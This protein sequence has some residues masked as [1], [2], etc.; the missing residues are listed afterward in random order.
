[1]AYRIRDLVLSILILALASWAIV[2]IILALALT[3]KRIFFTQIRTGKDEKPF[4]LIKFSTLRDILSGEKEEEAQRYRLTPVGKIILKTSLD[5]L[6]NLFNVLMG[7]MSLVGPRPLIHDYLPIYSTEQKKRFKVPPGITGWAQ[8][9]GRNALSFT[10][11]FKM[12]VWYVEHRSFTLD[13]KIV[14][15]TFGKIFRAGGVYADGE[16]TSPRFDGTN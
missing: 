6:P 16:N 9:N 10:E 2:L 15:K 8:V 1:M 13:L 14:G 7:E 5:E 4:R 12:D 11:R 3:Q